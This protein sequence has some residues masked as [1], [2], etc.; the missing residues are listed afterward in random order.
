MNLRSAQRGECVR[1]MTGIQFYSWVWLIQSGHSPGTTCH[2]FLNLQAFIQHNDIR[3]A[4]LST[5]C[6]NVGK[7]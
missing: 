1:V 6:K 7:S 3:F 2:L 5:E 4:K